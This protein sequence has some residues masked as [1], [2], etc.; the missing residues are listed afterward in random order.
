MTTVPSTKNPIIPGR[1]V[2]DPH[3]KVFD[4][5]CSLYASHD[6][7]VTNTDYDMRNWHVWSS[8]DFVTW[9]HEAVIDPT[10]DKASLNGLRDHYSVTFASHGSVS[11]S[12]YGPI[13]YR[14][15]IGAS[16]D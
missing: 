16:S 8:T 6:T 4:D 7:S 14:G 11:E 5:V 9:T 1:G 15:S 10:D 2:C 12:I 13:R 3:V